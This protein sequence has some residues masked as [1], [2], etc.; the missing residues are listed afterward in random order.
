MKTRSNL[1]IL[2]TIVAVILFGCTKDQN[3]ESQATKQPTIIEQ[4]A[5]TQQIKAY[6][7][8][9]SKIGDIAKSREEDD[10]WNK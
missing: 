7:D 8:M 9:Q 1:T 4:A 3:K 5:G 2:I 6:K 10:F